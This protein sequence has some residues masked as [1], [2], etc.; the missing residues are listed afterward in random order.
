MYDIFKIISRILGVSS[1]IDD[2]FVS[3]R[4]SLIEIGPL[5]GL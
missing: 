3:S 4:I 5:N 2:E 1:E